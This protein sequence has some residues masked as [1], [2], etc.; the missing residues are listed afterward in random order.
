MRTSSRQ[1]PIVLRTGA[2]AVAVCVPVM[3]CLIQTLFEFS[4][5]R[6]VEL[7]GHASVALIPCTSTTYFFQV[8]VGLRQGGGSVIRG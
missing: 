6:V 3:E 8:F 2:V 4:C 1:L 5:Y 7:L